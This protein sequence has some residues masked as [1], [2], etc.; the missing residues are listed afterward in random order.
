MYEFDAHGLDVDA[1]IKE[2]LNTLKHIKA[3][4]FLK[5]F[6]SEEELEIEAAVKYGESPIDIDADRKIHAV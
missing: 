2:G 3:A 1:A 4:R 5:R 6:T